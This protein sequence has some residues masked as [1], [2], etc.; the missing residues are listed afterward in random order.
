[1]NQT[2]AAEDQIGS[3]ETITNEIHH[4]ELANRLDS[5]FLPIELDQF[6]DNIHADVAFEPEIEAAHPVKIAAGRVD[7]RANFPLPDQGG[8]RDADRRGVVE[9]G[10][11]TGSRFL[12]APDLAM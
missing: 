6:R 12:A 10:P 2:I 11:A 7:H 5:V 1:M 3:R 9:V 4:A 8:Q